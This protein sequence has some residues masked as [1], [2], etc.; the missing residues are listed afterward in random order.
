MPSEAL[1]MIFLEPSQLISDLKVAIPV[2]LSMI[3]V[4]FSD[5]VELYPN[6]S[7]STSEK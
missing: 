1:N 2:I 5:I 4:M 7:P 3:T 6:V